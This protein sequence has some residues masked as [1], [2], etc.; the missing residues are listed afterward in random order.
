MEV[1]KELAQMI[2][3]EIKN[4]LYQGHLDKYT[5]NTPNAK[6]TMPRAINIPI[7]NPSPYPNLPKTEIPSFSPES[8]GN[9]VLEQYTNH[10]TIQDSKKWNQFVAPLF[11]R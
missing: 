2:K 9:W 10:T 6:Q 1:G 5:N 3:K 7:G 8:L 4:L 11:R